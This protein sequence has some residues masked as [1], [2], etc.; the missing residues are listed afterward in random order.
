MVIV[1]EGLMVRVKSRKLTVLE[2]GVDSQFNLETEFR[3]EV[4]SL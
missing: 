2:R 4:K 1:P 3:S